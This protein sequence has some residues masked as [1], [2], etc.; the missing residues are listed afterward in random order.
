MPRHRMTQPMEAWP[1]HLRARFETHPL[2]D[3][4]SVRL[5]H[6]LG[7]WLK[8]A[9]DL[10]VDAQDVSRE[11][12]RARTAGLPREVRND[13]RQALAV[14]FPDLATT[15]YAGEGNRV[16]RTDQRDHLNRMIVRN[17]ARFPEQWRFAATPLLHV[18]PEGLGDG[19]LV[20]AWAASTI[21]RR[22]ETAAA[23]FDYCRAR[24]FDIDITPMS[25]RA[26]LREDQARVNRGE[27][28][29]GG[30]AVDMEAMLGLAA[31]VSRDRSWAWL[32]TTRDR[33]KKLA[34]HC[35]SR[36]AARAVDAAEL[37][38]A[39]QQLLHQADADHAAACNRRD[40]VKAHTRA[41]TALVMILLSEAPIRISS[42]A[43]LELETGLLTDL[44]G[45][46]LDAASTK[47]G[48][49][50]RRVF[51]ATLVDAV[52]RYVRSHRAVIAAQGE[53]RLFVGERGGPI[54][55]AQLSTCLG[56]ITEPVFGVRVTPHAIRHSVANFIVASAPEEAALASTILNHRSDAT[57]PTYTQRADQIVASRRLRAAT[58]RIATDL[59]A[60]IAPTRRRQKKSPV[61]SR[62]HA[63]KS[64][65]RP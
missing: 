59:S 7:R 61:R 8:I 48:D 29:L 18:D 58:E 28:R 54:G 40:F 2:S 52:G 63:S 19:I 16:E 30:V 36:N 56:S 38:A 22:L 24:G 65:A 46:Y 11:T 21:K 4:Q 41:R 10:G 23:H 49:A 51:S 5:R 34:S 55:A 6:A 57:T 15:L 37:R 20:Q 33:L 1:S 31:A 9:A 17:L 47:E 35:G 32:R 50:D 14:V 13:V 62:P 60:D 45:L 44:A 25:V 53:T 12:W 39:G 42:C 26:K 3:A 27:R 64:A 43:S